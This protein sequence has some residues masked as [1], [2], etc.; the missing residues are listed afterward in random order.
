MVSCCSTRRVD[1][2][3]TD[4]NYSG[5]KNLK[6]QRHGTGNLTLPDGRIFQGFFKNGRAIKGQI[7]YPN[8]DSFDGTI[9]FAFL[10]VHGVMS[11]KNLIYRGPFSLQTEKGSSLPHGPRGIL[12]LPSQTIYDGAFKFGKMHGQGIVQYNENEPSLARFEGSFEGNRI[13][14]HGVMHYK[15]GSRCEGNFE[16]DVE[17]PLRQGKGLTVHSNGDRY[18]GNYSNDMR[19]GAGVASYAMHASNKRRKSFNAGND[20]D[21]LSGLNSS[22]SSITSGSATSSDQDL[23]SIKAEVVKK[24]RGRRRTFDGGSAKLSGSGGGGGVADGGNSLSVPATKDAQRPSAAVAP[25]AA[26]VTT[27]TTAR[28]P[29]AKYTYEGQWSQDKRH[30][31]GKETFPEGGYYNGEW[32]WDL[33]HGNG[34][35]LFPDGR[36]YDVTYVAGQRASMVLKADGGKKVLLAKGSNKAKRNG[37]SIS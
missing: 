3:G 19:Q 26:A 6:G 28:K 23:G 24:N 20:G 36:L 1:P 27:T 2:E 8:G 22:S 4:S 35:Y 12:V 13:S 5:G 32:E 7:Q 16:G 17:K 10:P 15:D 25:A 11:S 29:R 34:E 18:V 30:G 21:A 14:G 37:C 33:R 9:S 31:R